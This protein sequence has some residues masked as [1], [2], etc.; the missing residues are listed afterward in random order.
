M[1]FRLET[2]EHQQIAIHSVVEIF[3]GM[4]K[5]TYDNATDAT[6]STLD[7]L[8]KIAKVLNIDIKEL[9]NDK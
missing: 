1:R 2:P 7:T 4:E 6:Q 3:R 5:N 9:I 8:V